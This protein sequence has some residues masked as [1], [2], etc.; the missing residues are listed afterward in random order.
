MPIGSYFMIQNVIYF[1][2]ILM[3][4]VRRKRWIVTRIKGDLIRGICIDGMGAI[5]APTSVISI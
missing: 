4:E 5:A 2:P 1:A 3:V